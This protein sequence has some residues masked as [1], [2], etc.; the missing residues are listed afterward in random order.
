MIP[1]QVP[2]DLD[3]LVNELEKDSDD[4]KKFDNE[5]IEPKKVNIFPNSYDTT[6]KLVV[7]A[8]IYSEL[9]TFMNVSSLFLILRQYPGADC[10]HLVLLYLTTLFF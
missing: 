7:M 4:P 5:E 9:I 1:V 3:D 8:F 10:R 6:V 2:T